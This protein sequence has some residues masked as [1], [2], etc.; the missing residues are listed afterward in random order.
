MNRQSAAEKNVMGG[1]YKFCIQSGEYRFLLFY[2]VRFRTAFYCFRYN[3]AC[4]QMGRQGTFYCRNHNF[5]GF[6]CNADNFIC[7]GMLLKGD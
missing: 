4:E 1:G 7:I 6:A 3:I 5:I 2:N